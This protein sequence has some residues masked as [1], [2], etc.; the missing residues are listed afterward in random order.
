MQE[1][2][3]SNIEPTETTDYSEDEN[4]VNMRSESPPSIDRGSRLKHEQNAEYSANSDSDGDFFENEVELKRPENLAENDKEPEGKKKHMSL[5][6]ED[7]IKFFWEKPRLKSTNE[8]TKLSRE[9]RMER[10]KKKEMEALRG[11]ITE[12][13][14]ELKEHTIFR[15]LT[16]KSVAAE[17][18]DIYKT[19]SIENELESQPIFRRKYIPPKYDK[20]KFVGT[21]EQI[22]LTK[23]V[24][25]ALR[26]SL[27]LHGEGTVSPADKLNTLFN[28]EKEL[29]LKCKKAQK[30]LTKIPSLV[31]IQQLLHALGMYIETN[32]IVRSVLNTY[33]KIFE[34][35]E[36]Y[37]ESDSFRKYINEAMPE[38]EPDDIKDIKNVVKAPY[39]LSVTIGQCESIRIQE[40][41]K[42][43]R[44]FAHKGSEYG[45]FEL[46]KK[47]NLGYRLTDAP[48]DQSIMKPWKCS[49]S[50][51]TVRRNY[52][53]YANLC[54]RRIP[55][56]KGYA[57]GH[58][59]SKKKKRRRE[60]KQTSKNKYKRKRYSQTKINFK[61][62][63]RKTKKEKI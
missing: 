12:D 56:L 41:E 58:K 50:E 24:Y 29:L 4:S 46:A 43:L 17:I 18:G 44:L 25:K 45:K 60:K 39:N 35:F 11:F 51:N 32:K 14:E 2:S 59:F 47:L 38:A 6:V 19:E 8:V 37:T 33:T 23:S 5:Q 30:G 49:K 57:Y 1:Q 52:Q 16:R 54:P 36:N 26:E 9:A 62:K 27:S 20:D 61:S 7:F 40:A 3:D 10:L 34:Y 53:K 55:T 13:P 31:D 21:S 42:L 15:T 28:A 22:I 48:Q 63:K